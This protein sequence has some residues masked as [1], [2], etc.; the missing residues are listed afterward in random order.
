VKLQ[1]EEAEPDYDELCAG[2]VDVAAATGDPGEDVCGGED[3]AVGF[4]VAEAGSEPVVFYV[5]RDSLL[6]FEVEGL[7]QYAIDNG[8]TL[9]GEAGLD[10]LSIDELQ[11]TQTKLEQAIAGVG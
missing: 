1:V 6:R 2:S 7:I 3:A 9:P 4:H 5:N 11:E 10:P 8:E